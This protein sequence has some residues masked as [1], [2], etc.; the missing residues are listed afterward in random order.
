M[1]TDIAR[2]HNEA[3]AAY[4]ATIDRT[5][6]RM[7]I[8]IL[9]LR[10]VREAVM[11]TGDPLN[12]LGD[13]DT[14]DAAGKAAVTGIEDAAGRKVLPKIEPDE[15]SPPGTGVS[16]IEPGG[17]G[18]AGADV[19]LNRFGGSTPEPRPGGTGRGLDRLRT[20]IGGGGDGGSNDA[21]SQ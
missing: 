4:V 9:Y 17:A 13:V 20:F 19:D 8:H 2:E 16:P 14:T 3:S 15:L 11:R 10:Q 7:E 18:G 21:V 1:Q 12:D 5:I 6:R